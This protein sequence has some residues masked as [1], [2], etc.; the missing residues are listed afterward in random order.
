M[1]ETAKSKCKL[2][3]R[4]TN[5]MR[6]QQKEVFEVWELAQESAHCT[7]LGTNFGTNPSH[8]EVETGGSLELPGQTV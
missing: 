5:A 2:R 8:W 6:T 4:G 7:H 3:T 1:E